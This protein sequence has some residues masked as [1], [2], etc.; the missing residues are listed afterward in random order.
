MRAEKKSGI[1]NVVWRNDKPYVRI[2]LHDGP[3]GRVRVPVAGC[4]SD[5]E[6]RSRRDLLISVADRLRDAG[7]LDV[8]K[9]LLKKVGVREGKALEAVMKAI[10]AVCIGA[11]ARK[12]S[13]DEITFKDFA[14][15]WTSGRL[16]DEFPDHVKLKK[17]AD[18]DVSRLEKYV[19]P[20]I[21][22]LPLSIVGLDQAERVLQAVPTN[23]SAATRRHV[24]QLVRRVLQLAVYPARLIPE[25]PLPRGFLPSVGGGKAKGLLYPDEDRQLLGCRR[26]PLVWR[27]FWGVLTREGMRRDEAVGLDWVHIDLV[28]GMVR[29]DINKTD[30][31]RSWPL[32]PDVH[33][34]LKR[35]LARRGKVKPTDPVFAD[36]AGTRLK[37]DHAADVLRSHL[38]KAGVERDELLRSTAHRQALRAHDLRATFVTVSLA[39]GRSEAW[40]SDR[41]G[42]RSSQMIHRYYRQARSFAELG[43]GSL[44]PMHE[45]IPEFV[46]PSWPRG[47]PRESNAPLPISENPKLLN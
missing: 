9:D 47:G 22:D 28:R 15:Q 33:E 38:V 43:L 35:W 8:A 40:I 39:A 31:P 16:H 42:H 29:L 46:A 12:R 37:V 20:I 1:P 4:Q 5:A 19:Y 41:T 44:A 27:M 14:K 32:S 25:N 7:R 17:T 18:D 6:L 10:D 21:G 23:K 24:A 26:I 11:T 30:D 45:T 34:A 13:A 2:K 36:M 3:G